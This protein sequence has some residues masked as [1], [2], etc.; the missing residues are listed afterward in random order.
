MLNLPER[1]SSACTTAIFVTANVYRLF[2][3]EFFRYDYDL[4]AHKNFVWFTSYR[5]KI[6]K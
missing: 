2:H 5:Y 4:S 6:D 1:I 3:T